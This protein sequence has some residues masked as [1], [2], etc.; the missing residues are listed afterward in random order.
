[1]SEPPVELVIRGGQVVN[2]DATVT[3]DVLIA[4][5]RVLALCEPGQSISARSADFRELDASGAFVVPGGVD[6]HCH[7][8]FTSGAFTTLDDY[9]QATRAAIAGGTT[10][11]VDFAIPRPGES[12]LDAAQSQLTK[13]AQGFCD[14]ALHACVVEWHR[15]SRDELEYLN[16]IG[17]VTVKMFTTYRGETMA[18]SDTILSTMKVLRDVGGLAYIH[19]EANHMV[20]DLQ[21]DLAD[22]G[23]IDSSSHH[24]SRSEASELAAVRDVLATAEH[25]KGPVYFVHQSTP[26][27]VDA[28]MTARRRGVMAYSEAVMHHLLLDDT[29]YAAEDAELYVC[30]PPLRTR[31]T[32]KSLNRHLYSG[33]ITTLGSDHCCYDSEQ[34]RS[35]REDVR[36]MPNGL[37]GVQTR[38]PLAFSE[39]VLKG[40]LPVEKFVAL[41]SSNPARLNGLYPR[42]GAILPGSDADVVLLR[43]EGRTTIQASSLDMATDYTPFEGWL[44]DGTIQAVL[45]NGVVAMEEGDFRLTTR[46]GRHVP[47]SKLQLRTTY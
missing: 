20:E 32:V 6:P 45:V 25:L 41:T 29:K 44:V 38:V 11:I 23:A 1:M 4:E 21:R 30:C 42:K 39:F 16:S 35:T 14:S 36:A 8:G 2:A 7:V 19:A 15:D 5:G 40:G 12:T 27:A 26:Q 33:G 3:A 17:V 34:K 28:V 46:Q 31:E 13:A 24:L 9:A 47:G 22:K 18:S 10:T 43:P 37:P